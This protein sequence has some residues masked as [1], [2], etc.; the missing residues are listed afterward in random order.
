MTTTET[1]SSPCLTCGAC[2]AAYRVSFYWAEANDAPGG[3]VPVEFTEKVSPHRRAMRVNNVRELRCVCLRGVIGERVSCAI[4]PD[5]SST[6][7]EF[8]YDGEGGQANERCGQAR[9]RHG[10]PPLRA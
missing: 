7:R 1:V 8:L 2:C 3:T 9:A 6:C 4:Y 5:R 10:L